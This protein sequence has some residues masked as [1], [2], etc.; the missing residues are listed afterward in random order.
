MEEH[1]NDPCAVVANAGAVNTVDYDDL[2][3]IA[4]LKSDY[5]FWLHVDAAFGGFAACSPRFSHLA[6]GLEH[7]DSIAIDAHKW[8]NV[9]YDSAMQFTRHKSL[10]V[11]VFQNNAARIWAAQSLNPNL[12]I[13]LR[14]TP[15]VSTAL[16]AW[17]SLQAYGRAG[18]KEIVES[19]GRGSPAVGRKNRG[20]RQLRTARARQTEYRVLFAEK[21][22]E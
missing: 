6:N 2:A 1:R 21:E 18:Y 20:Q 4:R 16:S 13:S 11:D 12:L 14:K 5:A 15:D 10:Q 9:P 19:N 8:L 3:A 22:H 17:F 7:A